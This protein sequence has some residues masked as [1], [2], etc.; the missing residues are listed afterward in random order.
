MPNGC[1][2]VSRRVCI[3]SVFLS[4]LRRFSTFAVVKFLSRLLTAL[5][6]D[7][8]IATLTDAADKKKGA[9]AATSKE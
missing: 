9:S 1:S 7:P 8:S 5:N 4:S 2:T 6:F 3:A